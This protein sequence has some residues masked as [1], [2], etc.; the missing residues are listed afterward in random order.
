MKLKSRKTMKTRKNFSESRNNGLAVL[1]LCLVLLVAVESGCG[2][3]KVEE[4]VNTSSDVDPWLREDR[5]HYGSY[6]FVFSLERE[7]WNS[8][9]RRI[10]A[11]IKSTAGEFDRLINDEQFLMNTIVSQ[12]ACDKVIWEAMHGKPVDLMEITDPL[13]FEYVTGRF[14]DR[15]A[16]EPHPLPVVGDFGWYVKDENWEVNTG[17]TDLLFRC[18]DRR[19][20]R[21]SEITIARDAATAIVESRCGWLVSHDTIIDGDKYAVPN[22]ANDDC[23]GC[24]RVRFDLVKEDG[25]WLIDHREVLY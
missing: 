21:I 15:I 19:V 24:P 17:F 1:T 6:S 22:F 5:W 4:S 2:Q 16:S 10:H 23:N 3:S 25:K 14:R 11:A 7:G 9:Q 18:K 20:H 12:A 13:H 8:D